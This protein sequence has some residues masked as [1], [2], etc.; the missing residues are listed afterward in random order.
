MHLVNFGHTLN[1]QEVRELQYAKQLLENPGLAAKL[2]DLIGRPIEKGINLLPEKW[3]RIIDKATT[4]SLK[5]ALDLAVKSIDFQDRRQNN[6]GHKMAAITSGAV[7]GGFGL[8]SLPIELPIS[9]TIM[10][11]SIA[12][13]ANANGEDLTQAEA[14]LSCIE[15]FALGSNS[16]T[17]D[18]TETGYYAVRAALAKA[19]ADAAKYITE[20]GIADAGAP[21]LLKFIV[22]VASRFGI[23]VSQK[24][25]AT[26]VPIVGAAGGAVINTIFIDHFQKMA[27]GHFIVRRLERKYGQDIV[28]SEYKQLTDNG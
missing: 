13:I 24:A 7:G 9:T 28:R 20:R 12:K 17:D 3:H 1:S 16:K 23:V 6:F 26:A 21:A 27:E 2:T 15:V 10:L 5:K 25:A 4:K 19:V 22:K 14:R 18:A 8:V 11:R